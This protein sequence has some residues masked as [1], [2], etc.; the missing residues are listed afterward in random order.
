MQVSVYAKLNLTLFV[1]AREGRYHPIDSL[2]TSVDVF[3]EVRVQSRTDSKVLLQCD[4][5]IPVEKNSAYRAAVA[6]QQAFCTPGVEIFVQKGIPIGA[7]M[8]GS[9]ADAAAVV[10]CMSKLF[11]VDMRSTEVHEMCARLGSDVN[12]ML[13]GG[14]ARMQGKGDDLSFATLS[15]PI[16]FALTTFGVQLGSAEVYSAYDDLS[17]ELATRPDRSANVWYAGII[18]S[19]LGNAPSDCPKSDPISDRW[20]RSGHYP[21]VCYNGLQRASMSLNGYAADYIA[22]TNSMGWNSCMTGSGSAYFV[23]F[24]EQ[25][26]AEQAVWQLN[27]KGFETIMCRA[28]PVGI[29]EVTT[30]T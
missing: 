4:A 5:D 21:I 2:V 20:A 8:G 27:G 10:Y 13:Q 16:Y 3:D 29:R 17:V 9:S 26:A 6:F 22:F 30:P 23:P 28:V 25:K 11:G 1:Y 24:A 18:S 19:G 7:G 12:F 14:F 15:Q